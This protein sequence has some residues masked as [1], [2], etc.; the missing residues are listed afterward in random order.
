MTW[1]QCNPNPKRAHVED[2]VIRAIAIATGRKWY[3]VY[4][5]LCK[6]GREDANV[7]SA[8]AVWGKYLY[9]LGFEPFLL[10][11]ACPTCTTIRRFCEMFPVGTFIIGTGTHAVCV[12]DGDYYD[13]WD[14]GNEVPSYFWRV[15]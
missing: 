10:P 11:D 15:K 13:S 8:N 5:A 4:D 7:I 12:I 2:C 1:I 6:Q 14:S 3:D 9:R